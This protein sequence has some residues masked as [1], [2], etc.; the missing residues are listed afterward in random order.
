MNLQGDE[1]EIRGDMIDALIRAVEQERLDMAT[2]C[3]IIDDPRD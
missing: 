1:P 2:L 3:S